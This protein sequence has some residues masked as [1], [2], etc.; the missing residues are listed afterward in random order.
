MGQYY[1]VIN[2]AKR[3]YLHPHKFG[4]GLKL[5]EFGCSGM[6]T[7]TGLAVLLADGN[8][9]GGGDIASANA[10]VGSW[11]GDPIVI[12]GDYADKGR[13]VSDDDLADWRQSTPP[14]DEETFRTRLTETVTLQDLASECYEDISYRVIAALCEE[15]YLRASFRKQVNRF[16]LS[17]DMP[18]ELKALLS[19]RDLPWT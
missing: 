13:F 18:A 6:G 1:Y 5:M 19:G 11:A 12:S 17:G 4:D 3:Q 14:D 8:G 16:G 10:I 2:T 7:M 15:K 9:R